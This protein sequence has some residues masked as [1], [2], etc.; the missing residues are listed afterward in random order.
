MKTILVKAL[1]YLGHPRLAVVLHDLFMVWAGWIAARALSVSGTQGL[2]TTLSA[3]VLPEIPLVLAVQ[4]AVFWWTGLYRGLWRF[5]SLPDLWNLVRGALVGAVLVSAALWLSGS[6][7]LAQHPWAFAVYPFALVLLLGTPRLLF[8]TWKDLSRQQRLEADHRRT[9]ILGAGDSGALLLKELQRRGG[10][11]VVGFLDDNERLKGAHVRG[12]RV[13]GT[14]SQLPRLAEET[15]ATLAVIAMP[16]ANNQ[17]M[18][19]VVTLCEQAGIEFKTIPTLQDIGQR[20][21]RLDELKDVALE[22]LLGREPVTLDWDSLHRALVGKRVLITGGGGSIG[23][24]L[25]RLMARL[26]PA[27]LTVLDN[28][29]FNL[30]RID[31]E[32]R[33][34][35]HDLAFDSVLGDVCDPATVERTLATSRPEVIFHA[36][37]YKH[38]PMLQSQLREAFRNNVLGTRLVAQASARHGVETL[39]LISTDKAVN[40]ANVM[41]ATKRIAERYCRALNEQSPTRFMTVRFGNVL[42]STGSVV[43]LFQEQIRNGGPV[44]VTHPRIRRYFMSATEAGQLILQAAAI[45]GGGEIFVL[46]MGEPVSIRYLAE[47]LIRLAGKMPEKDIEI[48]YTGLRPGEKLFEELFYANESLRPTRHSKI[49]QAQANQV[50]YEALEA[51]LRQAERAVGDYDLERL[52]RLLVKLVPELPEPAADTQSGRVVPIERAG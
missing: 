11:R 34:D 50:D 20:A 15:A 19:R 1:A 23:A 10:F 2:E 38:L 49:L 52:R 24:E 12:V 37:A 44:T 48:V 33:R 9:V 26:N 7:L 13:L 51:D 22:D 45:G 35:Y 32:L 14:V 40:P 42:N 25:C 30:Y 31:R 17:Q 21:V 3:F 46:D 29:E 5:A 6:Q 39:V 43:P 47:Q 36:A 41:G 8:R 4:G 28:C 27:A 18:Q 16:S